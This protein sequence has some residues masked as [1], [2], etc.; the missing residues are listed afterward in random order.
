MELF[1]DAERL[2]GVCRLRCMTAVAVDTVYARYWDFW[3]TYKVAADLE[4]Q[5]LLRIRTA[6]IN[7]LLLVTPAS[8]S[9]CLSLVRNRDL[10]PDHIVFLFRLEDGTLGVPVVTELAFVFVLQCHSRITEL[11]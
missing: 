4:A 5:L 2:A 8:T 7:F 11:V 1:V 9:E 6:P 3:Q 10:L